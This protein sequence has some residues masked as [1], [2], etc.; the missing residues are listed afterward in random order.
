MGN[1]AETQPDFSAKHD[2]TSLLEKQPNTAVR[3]TDTVRLQSELKLVATA[4]TQ[5]P[6][7][8]LKV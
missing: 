1:V 3:P 7:Q 5:N 2:R 4:A 6:R 8:R